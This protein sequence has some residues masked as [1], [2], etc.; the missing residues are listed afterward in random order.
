MQNIRAK[1]DEFQRTLEQAERSRA[2]EKYFRA[3]WEL[4]QYYWLV[5]ANRADPQPLPDEKDY[6]ELQKLAHESIITMG[7]Q[8]E[9]SLRTLADYDATKHGPMLGV[10]ND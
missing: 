3:Y 10:S 8:G 9:F 5:N 1:I 2:A 6:S 4:L 7:G